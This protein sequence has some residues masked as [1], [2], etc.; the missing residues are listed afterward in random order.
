L[1]KKPEQLG[2]VLK[3]EVGNYAR[4]DVVRDLNEEDVLYFPFTLYPNSEGAIE[5]AGDRYKK[6]S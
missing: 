4:L 6:Y 2:L 3:C 1:R 5:S